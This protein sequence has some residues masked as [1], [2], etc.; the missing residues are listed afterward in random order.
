MFRVTSR[1]DLFLSYRNVDGAVKLFDFGAG[2][3]EP[4]NYKVARAPAGWSLLN[5]AWNRYMWLYES[6]PYI[7]WSG[8]PAKTH[9][10]W[11]LEQQ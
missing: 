1:P 8:D 2:V 4:T 10:Q 11:Y 9:S 3:L 6:S 5:P 7:S